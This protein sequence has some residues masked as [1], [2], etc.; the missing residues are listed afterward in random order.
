MTKQTNQISDRTIDN[1]ALAG[2]VSAIGMSVALVLS[3]LCNI[4]ISL[5]G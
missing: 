5:L 2:K 3:A 4:A 1:L